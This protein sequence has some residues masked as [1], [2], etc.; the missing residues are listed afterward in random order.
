[1]RNRRYSVVAAAFILAASCGC[2]GPA[3]KNV[4]ADSRESGAVQYT[5]EVV[6]T[7]PHR[8]GSYT[9]GLYW[10]DGYLWEGTGQYGESAIKKVDLTSGEAVWEHPIGDEYFGEGIT[11]LDGR[12]YQL[13]WLEGKAFVYDGQTLAETGSFAYRGEGWGLTTDG[14][15]LYMSDGSS[16]IFV[17]DP[18]DF[19]RK[20]A[21]NVRLEGSGVRYLNEL[22]WIDGKIWANIYTTDT[23][24]IIDPETGSVEGVVDMAGLL[25]EEDYRP[26]TDVL[27]GIAY[28]SEG[29]RIFVTGKYWNKLFEI[30]IKEK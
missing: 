30:R 6:N 21:I 10:H 19:S 12:I 2:R 16:Q 26:E 17:I 13:T 28:D 24:V 7:Y 23:V 14:Q 22:E 3:A 4:A 11:L 15:A 9:Q 27:N 20:K 29:Q 5:Y 25:S 18:S 1:M 8:T